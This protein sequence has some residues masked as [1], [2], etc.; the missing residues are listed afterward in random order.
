MKIK[1]K[2]V[3]NLKEKEVYDKVMGASNA[4]LTEVI[5]DI[6]RDVKSAP[7]TG[8][9]VLTGFNRN[10]IQYRINP[11]SGM[12]FSTS[13]YGGWLEIGTSRMPAR[14]HFKPAYDRHYPKLPSRIKARI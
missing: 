9:P 10:S 11:L 13:G 7:P 12:V 1:T 6:T 5:V 14:P 3:L 4:S 8:S 2:W